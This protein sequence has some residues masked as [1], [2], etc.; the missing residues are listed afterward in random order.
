M[1]EKNKEKWREKIQNLNIDEIY[2]LEKPP[3]KEKGK[4]HKSGYYKHDKIFNRKVKKIISTLNELK[5]EEKNWFKNLKKSIFNLF[6]EKQVEFVLD[7]TALNN[8]TKRY[9]IDLEKNK[10][11]F[12]DP[13]QLLEK[14]KDLF[15][16]KFKK[17]P[18]TK[19]QITLLYKMT[20]INQVTKE[21]KTD[22]PHF[23]SH[24]HQI[25][26]KSD[27]DEIYNKMKD[28]IIQSF[29]K[30]MNEGSQWVFQKSIK[31]FQNISDINLLRG[32]SYIPLSD[33][34][35]KKKALINPKNYDQ[36]C[37]L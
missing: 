7:K 24:Q 10:L 17:F 2:K 36:K 34:L 18:K 1:I 27:F 15:F 13:M 4:Y 30:Y 29:E 11:S 23:N 35:K 5:G 25:L 8:V 20:K 9:V 14:L 19:Q 21:V 3:E 32:P 6:E 31:F 28:K 16:E 33:H 22:E 26:E 12:Y 37:F